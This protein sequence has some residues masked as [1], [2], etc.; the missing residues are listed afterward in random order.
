MRD[1]KKLLSEFKS[2][3]ERLNRSPST[4]ESYMMHTEAFLTTV[5][6]KDIRNVNTSLIETWI[7]GLYDH[8]TKT[9]KPYALSTICI[10]IRSVKRFFEYLGLS[11]HILI[12]PTELIKEPKL[13]KSLRPVLTP[14]EAGRILNQPDLAKP[15]GVRDRTILEVFYSTGIRLNELCSLKLTDIDFETG[16]LRINRGK[17]QKDRVVPLGRHARRFLNGYITKIRPFFMR[18]KPVCP[19]L[20]VDHFGKQLAPQV[21]A[22]MVKT[23]AR[24]AGIK[25]KVTAHV[26]RHTFATGLIKNNADIRAVQLMMGHA[27]IRSTQEYTRVV[28]T[29]LKREHSK[30]HPREIDEKAKK[31]KP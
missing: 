29:D 13:N 5:D 23:K 31:E 2:H 30:T 24:A 20:F 4:I 6:V 27:D 10:I 26:F 19:Y 21:V 3:L 12:D 15:Y 11:G 28:A 17:G 14:E 16:T 18:E 22:I 25:K 1:I 9:G 7:E 8:K